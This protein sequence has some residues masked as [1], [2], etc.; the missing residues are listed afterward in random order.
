MSASHLAPLNPEPDAYAP[1]HPGRGRRGHR[2]SIRRGRLFVLLIFAAII[3]IDGAALDAGASTPSFAPQMLTAWI[4]AVVS[5]LWTAVFLGAVWC[6]QKWARYI[7]IGVE[8][9]TIGAALLLFP[10]SFEPGA[11][12]AQRPAMLCAAAMFLLVHGVVAWM[13]MCSHDLKRLTTR[14]HL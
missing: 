14:A 11:D 4:L 3:A 7:L 13:L 10:E 6:R 9:L 5:V 2:R 12:R 8:V 1:D